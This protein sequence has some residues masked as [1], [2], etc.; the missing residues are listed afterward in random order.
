M[1]KKLINDF[2]FDQEYY[3]IEV[4]SSL[5]DYQFAWLI[6]AEFGFDFRR[7]PNLKVLN[8]QK[9]Q[10][11]DHSFFE[12]KRIDKVSYYL[13]HH[14][15]SQA[16]IMSI[17]YIFIQS[18]ERQEVIEKLIDQLPNLPGILSSDSIFIGE[19]DDLPERYHTAAV[20]NRIQNIHN[21]LYDLEDYLRDKNKQE[22]LE[23]QL[24]LSMN[25]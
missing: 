8:F 2:D 1:A 14:N 22:K 25:H 21:I 5:V 19:M 7:L 9:K 4:M 17:Y 11:E 23:K 24:K 20:K 10:F 13:L 3:A 16:T 18:I 15:D 6:N 12:W